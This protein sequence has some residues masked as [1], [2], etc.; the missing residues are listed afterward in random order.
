VSFDDG[1][2]SGDSSAPSG[3]DTP[4]DLDNNPHTPQ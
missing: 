1:G 4:S 3:D 2:S